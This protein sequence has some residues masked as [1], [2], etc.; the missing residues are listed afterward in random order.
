MHIAL[1]AYRSQRV[2]LSTYIALDTYRS[3][4][5]SLS[6][7]RQSARYNADAEDQSSGTYE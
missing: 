4:R 2:S 5:V 3:R 1:N 7:L 6:T